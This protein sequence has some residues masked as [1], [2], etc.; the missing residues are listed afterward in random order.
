MNHLK[1]T[2][3]KQEYSTGNVGK[4]GDIVFF[5]TYW[6]ASRPKNDESS[7]NDNW[8]LCCHLPQVKKSLGFFCT[9]E[10]AYE[11]AEYILIAWL[12]K[13]GLELKTE[14]KEVDNEEK[15]R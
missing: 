3:R 13:S 15:N 8:G 12:Q 4:C 7:K 5:T 2:L 6:N 11:R 10:E 1:W 14:Q 9:E